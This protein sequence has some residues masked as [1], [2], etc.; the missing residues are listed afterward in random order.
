M[1][2]L[3]GCV[4]LGGITESAGVVIAGSENWRGWLSFARLGTMENVGS[5]S[6]G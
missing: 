4:R 2:R 5:R 3:A 1:S 6:S